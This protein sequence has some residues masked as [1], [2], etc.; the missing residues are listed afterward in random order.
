MATLA[1]LATLYSRG[2]A[3][4]DALLDRIKAAVLVSA[5]AIRVEAPATTN[6]AERLLWAKSAFSDPLARA[7][8]LWGAMLAANSTSTTAAILAASD[9]AIQTAV[10]NAVNTYITLP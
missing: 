3:Q 1:E 7:H 4:S 6:H 9:A 8:E 2:T 5:E 10:N